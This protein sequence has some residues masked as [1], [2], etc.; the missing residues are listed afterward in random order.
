MDNLINK[1]KIEQKLP[2]DKFENVKSKYILEILLDNLE[3]KKILDILKY[4]KNI[5][6]RIN[7]NI[8]DYIEYSEKYSSIEIE[9]KPKGNNHGKFINFKNEDEKYYHIYFNNNKEEIRRNYLNSNEDIKIIKIKID[10]QV[11]SFERLFE[12]CDC[13]VSIYFKQFFRNNINNMSFMF[14]DCSSLEEL[15]LNNFKTINVTKMSDMF[16][17]CSLLK[18]L[19][20]NNFNI[21]N[22]INMGVMLSD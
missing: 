3:K 15:S 11:E 22:V 14:S 9:I 13:I 4:N 2:K 10:Y 18:E 21:T 5:S 20:L 7:I 12:Y 16:N 19:N 8:N 17:K 1:S 6:N